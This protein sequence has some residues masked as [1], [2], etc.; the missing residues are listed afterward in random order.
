MKKT[1][2]VLVVLA[3]CGASSSSSVPVKGKDADVALLAGKWAGEY[4]GVQSGRRGSISFDLSLGYHT[5]EGQVIMHPGGDHPAVPLQIK[6]VSVGSGNIGGKIAPYTDPGCNCTV[7]TEFN[8]R[9][10]GAQMS[11][12][13]VTRGEGLGEQTG[14]WSAQ[15]TGEP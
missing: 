3:A 10:E 7:E 1:S 2:L 15:R 11:G 6:F 9:I 5:A 4:E 14:R 12:T 8:G 13:F